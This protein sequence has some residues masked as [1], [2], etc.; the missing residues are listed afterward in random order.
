[1]L[2]SLFNGLFDTDMTSVIAV[3]DFLLCVAC[4]LV[5]GLILTFGYMYRSRYTKSFLLTLALLPA[6]VCVVIMMVNGNIGAGVAVAGAFSLVRFRSVPGTAREI[7][8]LFLAMG[9]GLI[10]G[11]GYLGYA[12]LFTVILCA[13]SILYNRMDLGTKRNSAMYKTLH[14][15]I[16][17]DLDYSSVFDGVL[18][19]YASSHELVRVKT[20]NMGSLFKLTYDLTL[21]DPEK[22]MIDKLR[23]RNGNLEITVSKQETTA[24]SCEIGGNTMK[25]NVFAVLLILVLLLSGCGAGGTAGGGS[26]LAPEESSGS[27]E[28]AP[29]ESTPAESTPAAD[30]ATTVPLNVSDCFSDRNIDASYD[31]ESSAIIEL[32]GDTAS[33][34]SNAVR[35][36]GS[37]V[38]ITDEGTYILTGTLNDGT[39]IVNADKTDKTQLV[40]NNAVINSE[41][42]AAIYVLQADKVFISLAPDSVNT[43]F[44]GGNFVA[45]DDNNIDAV[46][47]SKDDITFNGSGYLTVTSPAG[48]GIVSKDEL[49]LCG[50]A[51]EI[52]AA[53]HGLYG[54][55]SVCVTATTLDITSVKDGIHA[56]NADNASLG[57]VYI[58]SGIFTITAEGDGVSAAAQMQ[59]DD[60]DFNI[61]AG[62]GSTNAEKQTSD[63]WGG[64]PGGGRG[65]GGWPTGTSGTNAESEEESTSIKGI[66]ASGNLLIQGGS[67]M[68]DSADDAVHTNASV[69]VQDGIFDISTGDDGFHA[70]D[71]LSVTGGEIYINECYEGL[72]GL[73][74]L[75]SGGDITLTA[76]DDGL[77][78]TGGTDQ[79]GFDGPRMGDKF[80]GMAGGSSDGSIEI[81][82]GRLNI[83]SS[84]DGLD[85][86]GTLTIS[87]GYTVVCGPTQGDTATLDYDV[88]G[89]IMGGTFIGSGASFMAESFSDAAR[90]VIAINI[91][92][93]QA[94]TAITL[95][96]AS[97]GTILSHTPELPY[98]V[99]ILSSLDI[100]KGQQYTLTIGTASEQITAK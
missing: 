34:G 95:Q 67:F 6:V 71:T 50:G 32:N 41:T 78:A 49:T 23:C 89:V 98:A 81:S 77:N 48:H 82:G 40:L 70:D 96:N 30:S 3:S 90:G 38:T 20:T 87:G 12:V 74:V 84:G 24:A 8:M 83:T 39:V 4:S 44:N 57:Y 10:A 26:T 17:E 31:E 97:G 72:E 21:K 65:G 25:R 15:T 99:V 76:A 54:K 19:E 9:A 33:C 66:K 80:G 85:A 42:S 13:L 36:Y 93:Q 53:A 64:F 79:S 18:S 1:M 94:G 11:M 43:L 27:T 22:E 35:I 59:I 62:G 100:I 47:F 86:N 5:I 75:V 69:T 92:D 45:I 7:T 52:S 55:D 68:I 2:D 61:V 37:T 73:H 29:S 46:V 88:S 58:Q 56:E 16:P 91:G 60:G 63:G 14:I 28:L 51:Y